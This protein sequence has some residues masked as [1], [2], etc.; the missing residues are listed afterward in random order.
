MI[1]VLMNKKEEPE[2]DTP[3]P[4]VEEQRDSIQEANEDL[5]NLSI[6]PDLD[7]ESIN[8]DPEAVEVEYEL[9]A[10][11]VESSNPVARFISGYLASYREGVR[12]FG[13]WWKIFQLSIWSIAFILVATACI[14]LIIYLPKIEMIKWIIK[15]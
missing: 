2:R 7:D 9:T 8:L 4:I 10:E 5:N 12:R 11:A 3:Y 14:I 1:S 6:N 15:Q 13:V